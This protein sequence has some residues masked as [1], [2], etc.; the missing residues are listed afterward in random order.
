LDDHG[1]ILWPKKRTEDGGGFPRFKRYIGI[2]QSIQDVI[3]D[4]PPINSQ[5]QEHLGYPTQKPVALLERIIQASS[6]EGETVLDP[7][8]GCGTTIDAAQ[9]L[10]RAWIGIDLTYLAI[11]LIKHRLQDT[12][13]QQVPYRVRGE[14]TSLPDAAALAAEDPY[15]F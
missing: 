8:C 13:R 12:F 14:P 4:I 11:A 15:Q 5:A 6:H 9:R 1:F 7:F 3:T 10:K 2:G